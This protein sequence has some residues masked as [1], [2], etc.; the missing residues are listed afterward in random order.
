MYQ[1][2][3]LYLNSLIP[4]TEDCHD[5]VRDFADTVGMK[6]TDALRVTLLCEE[7]VGMVSA[8]MPE[9]EAELW[10][11]GDAH[12]CEVHL[13]GAVRDNSDAD[14]FSADEAPRG[15]MMKIAEML[16]CAFLFD[17]R[18]SVPSL[19]KAALPVDMRYGLK[20]GDS[21]VM[22]GQWS[23][24]AY[25]QELGNAKTRDPAA[26]IALDELEKSI[27]ASIAD[28]VIVGLEGGNFNIV[29]TKSF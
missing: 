29:I 15:L 10:L 14:S 6:H 13:Q 16:R 4:R 2:D 28:D 11:A 5:M 24:A 7:T 9:F 22:A 8:M 27:V 1:T 18:D 17:S 25:R 20:D 23:L 12:T 3:K 19:L 26:R 21:P